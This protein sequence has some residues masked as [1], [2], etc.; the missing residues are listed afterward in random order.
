M[1]G[2]PPYRFNKAA[3]LKRF[4]QRW[5]EAQGYRLPTGQSKKG[6][7]LYL[8]CSLGGDNARPA[9]VD[10]QRE[11]RNRWTGCPFRISGHKSHHNDCLSEPWELRPSRFPHNHGPINIKY[12]TVHKGLDPKAQEEVERLYSLGLKPQAIA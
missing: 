9:G 4:A 3:D 2:P 11:S 7:N 12:E 6:K 10:R 5:E 8:D 1:N